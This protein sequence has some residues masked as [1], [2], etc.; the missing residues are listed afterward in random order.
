MYVLEYNT[1]INNGSDRPSGAMY[2]F[3][4]SLI[5]IVLLLQMHGFTNLHLETTNMEGHIS[6]QIITS[7]TNSQKT[8]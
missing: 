6:V 7:K 4:Y 8:S 1:S 2:M 3:D 5:E